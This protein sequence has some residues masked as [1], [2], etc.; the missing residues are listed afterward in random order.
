MGRR[1][2][3]GSPLDPLLYSPLVSTRSFWRPC[4]IVPI[5]RLFRS[6]STCPDLGR[7][8]SCRVSQPRGF[9][10]GKLSPKVTDEGRPGCPTG[11]K[12]K[13]RWGD[14]RRPPF[15]YKERLGTGSPLIR[16][17]FAGPPSP[18]GEG[19]GVGAFLSDYNTHLPSPP[20]WG[21]AV[22]GIGSWAAGQAKKEDPAGSPKPEA[23]SPEGRT[24][25]LWPSFP[26]S[27]RNGAPTGRA[28]TGRRASRHRNSPDHAKGTQ[29]RLGPGREPT[30]QVLNLR[31]SRRDHL[32]PP[33]AESLV[34]SPGRDRTSGTPSPAPPRGWGGPAPAAGRRSAGGTPPRRRP[35]GASGRRGRGS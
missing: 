32:P 16:P 22:T 11:Q 12:K 9:P 13:F 10:S 1:R 7:F 8:F 34:I 14:R 15:F 27:R 29:Y 3:G 25:P 26:V 35:P 20:S 18:E 30:W 19:F 6:P 4:R 2:A 5:V 28:P 23:G 21:R 31:W 17:G 24:S 33:T